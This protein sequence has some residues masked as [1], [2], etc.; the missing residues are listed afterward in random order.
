MWSQVP[1]PLANTPVGAILG[2]L[3]IQ[4]LPIDASALPAGLDD[5]ALP[6]GGQAITGIVGPGIVRP[7]TGSGFLGR[8]LKQIIGVSS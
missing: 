5:I 8:R 3:H 4:P 2:S 1:N 6:L 7:D